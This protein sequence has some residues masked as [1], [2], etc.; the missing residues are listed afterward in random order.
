MMDAALPVRPAALHALL[1]ER[2]HRAA[3]VPVD[4]E[5]EDGVDG[6]VGEGEERGQQVGGVGHRGLFVVH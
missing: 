1:A 5:E 4:E 2:A 6:G 3:V